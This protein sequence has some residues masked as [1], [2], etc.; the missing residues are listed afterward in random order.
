MA[1]TACGLAGSPAAGP[2]VEV[3]VSPCP[4]ELVDAPGWQLVETPVV[5]FCVPPGWAAV[6]TPGADAL[7]RVQGAG[8]WVEWRVGP[9]PR[10]LPP[11]RPQLAEV[12]TDW[13]PRA[14]RPAETA[15]GMDHRIRHG[16]T[17][18]PTTDD[19]PALVLLS[20]SARD[21]LHEVLLRS[22]RLEGAHRLPPRGYFPGG[23][24][25]P[26]DT[27]GAAFSDLWYS[28]NLRAMGEPR[29]AEAAAASADE[30]FRL[31]V[32]PSFTPAFAVRLHRRGPGAVVVTTMLSGAGGYEPG[33][34]A[35]HDSVEVTVDDAAAYFQR[36]NAAGF[37]SMPVQGRDLGFDG[38]EWI[39]EGVRDGRYHVVDRWTPNVTG[40]H[41][42][43]LELASELLRLGGLGPT[44]GR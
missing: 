17:Y 22:V 34:P 18:W 8:G 1:A 10:A 28:R 4:A 20:R 21:T 29:L 23:M 32:L 36:A 30:V 33:E 41:P 38:S 14:G 25:S 37:W 16:W 9:F 42:E 39:L 13:R 12:R 26:D 27:A 11:P 43:F 31:T 19:A 44:P 2:S 24:L 35:R 40:R 3:P 6:K 15:T 5:R 7:V